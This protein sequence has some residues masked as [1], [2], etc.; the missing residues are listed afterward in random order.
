MNNLESSSRREKLIIILFIMTIVPSLHACGKK[1]PQR[2]PVSNGGGQEIKIAVSL[3]S[4]ERTA[5]RLSR[6]P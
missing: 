1:E 4:M 5:T 6:R 3:A 2:K